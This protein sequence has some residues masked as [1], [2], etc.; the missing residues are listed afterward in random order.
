MTVGLL[1]NGG[2]GVEWVWGWV[3]DMS[4]EAPRA[5][6]PAGPLLRCARAHRPLG[7]SR[8]PPQRKGPLEL[9]LGL[10]EVTA[11]AA[12]LLKPRD[13]MMTICSVGIFWRMVGREISW[14]VWR[15]VALS[16]GEISG[17]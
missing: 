12:K 16:R 10:G 1:C 7:L 3:P 11:L 15:S 2:I 17:V 8:G 6:P 13:L 5:Q 9:G 4:H 14:L